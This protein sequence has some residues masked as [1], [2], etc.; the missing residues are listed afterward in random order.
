M[1]K[2][3]MFQTTS[4]GFI[5]VVHCLAISSSMGISPQHQ[6]LTGANGDRDLIH[7]MLRLGKK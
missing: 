6:D 3:N 5:D 7:T 2:L 1:E 4:Y